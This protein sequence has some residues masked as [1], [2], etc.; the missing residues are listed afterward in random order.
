MSALDLRLLGRLGGAG[1]L[2]GARSAVRPEGPAALGHA[3][4]AT[5]TV[6]VSVLTALG[7]IAAL[8]A[9][10]SEDATRAGMVLTAGAYVALGVSGLAGGS[11][12]A[13]GPLFVVV[14]A[15]CG[16]ALGPSYALK[17][18]PLG[19]ACATVPAWLGRP[20]T[21]ATGIGAIVVA[22]VTGEIFA[23]LADRVRRD[24]RRDAVR[25]RALERLTA[26]QLE[27]ARATDAREAANIAAAVARDILDAA[28]TTITLDRDGVRVVQ[29]AEARRPGDPRQECREADCI[30]LEVP[31][32]GRGGVG[33]RGVL[34]A[35]P[36]PGQRLDPF[37]QTL[38]TSLAA[39]T[40]AA[41]ESVALSA[42]LRVRAEVDPAHRPGQPPPAESALAKLR[43]GDIVI[44]IDLDNFKSVNDTL[45]HDVGDEV[46]RSFGKHL[47]SSTRS[48]ELAIRTGGEEFILILTGRDANHHTAADA[49][50]PAG[51][52]MVEPVA[53]DHLQ[54]GR[55]RPPRRRSPPPPIKRADQALYEAKRRGRAAGWVLAEDM[56][57]AGLPSVGRLIAFPGEPFPR[58][59]KLADI[60]LPP[61][62]ARAVGR[63]PAPRLANDAGHSA[64]VSIA[65]PRRTYASERISQL[66]ASSFVLKPV[67]C[68]GIMPEA[69][70]V[71]TARS[72]IGRAFKGSLKDLRPDDLA[73]TVVR[74]ALDKVPQ[75][76][77]ADIDDLLLGCGLPGGEQGFNMARV[78]AVLLG[79]D[80][81]PG[82]TVTRY[83]SSSLQTTRMALH[84]IKAGEG[85]VFV[86]AGVEMVSRYAKGSSDSLPD[87]MNPAFDEA[88]ESAN[89]QAADE[90]PWVDP[91]DVGPAARR[92]HRDGPDRGERRPA[93]GRLPRRSRTSSASA[94]RTS[95]RRPSPTASGSARSPRSRCRTAPSSAKDDG[96]RAGRHARGHLQRSS[97]SSA[98][99][100]R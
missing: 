100:A 67:S 73:A 22:T 92:L 64:D 25:T 37:G 33:V 29:S 1:L 49:A 70:I 77:P 88:I 20:G 48:G 23:R 36:R 55:R 26:G 86:S 95:P 78:V 3:Q 57:D 21:A 7:G 32:T 38:L 87:T 71:A 12:A 11:Q 45:G 35:H 8:R 27:L 75:L 98:R 5:V 50:R 90:S 34:T 46:L 4:A 51:H 80:S 62:A 69:V 63:R 99:T 76:D 6:A 89:Q 53:A 72:P 9:R 31:L 82:T 96:P 39:A 56:R 54:R 81:V 13:Y 59:P 15:W 97:R 93:Q 91:R 61:A 44:A 47:A 65:R 42:R 17:L 16:L 94:R 58:Q 79:Y 19:V 28:I 18:S 68:G 60:I 83:C 30:P 40:S 85:D 84:A 52:R 24:A 14:A 43:A 66:L 2:A 10:W 74:A 41:L